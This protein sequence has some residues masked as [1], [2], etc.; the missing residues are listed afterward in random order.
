VSTTPVDRRSTGSFRLRGL[1]YEKL[2]NDLTVENS[3]ADH[4]F[5]QLMRK[6]INKQTPWL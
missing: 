5:K 3:V 2:C 4:I 1:I 6:T